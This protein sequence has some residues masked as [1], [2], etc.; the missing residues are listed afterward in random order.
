VITVDHDSAEVTSMVL[1]WL[2]RHV[3]PSSVTATITSAG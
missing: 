3:P 1:D 2:E